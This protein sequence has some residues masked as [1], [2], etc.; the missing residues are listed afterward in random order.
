MPIPTAPAPARV[1]SARAR[2]QQLARQFAKDFITIRKKVA[3]KGLLRR[4]Y[5]YYAT[6]AAI[7]LVVLA[8]LGVAF[9]FIGD[10]WWQLLIA[11]ALGIVLTQF[12]FIGHDAAHMQIFNDAR[13]NE[14][15][16]LGVAN[17]VVGLSYGWWD[18]KHSAHHDHPNKVGTDPDIDMKVLSFTHDQA[19]NASP[20]VR[21]WYQRQGYLF[22]LL[23]CLEGINLHYQSF[24]GLFAPGRKYRWV[25]AAFL[26]ARVGGLIAVVFWM[27]SP[28]IAVAFLGVQM[29]VFGFYMGCSFAPNHK[30]MPIVPKDL[31]I[32]FFRRQV[33][34]SRNIR[35]GH[36]IDILFGGLNYQI[37]HHLFPA[38][39]RASLRKVAPMIREYCREKQVVYTEVSMRE[40]YAALVAYL[41]RVGL[42]ARDPFNCP[43]AGQLRMGL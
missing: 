39:P 37:E 9:A 11:A 29:A 24:K 12:A 38:M 42:G 3:A 35:G 17:L 36:F 21:A 22:F 19:E 2:Q 27:L 13:R 33:L 43:L 28:G 6:N 32:D 23:V 40:S 7:L 18:R 31:S 5:G 14:W 20:L 10:S 1:A 26:I 30:G 25:E 16:S 41:N 34:M 4:R 15:A 8:G